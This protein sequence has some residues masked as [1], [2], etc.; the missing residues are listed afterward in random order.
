MPNPCKSVHQGR[1]MRQVAVA[2][3]RD[4]VVRDVSEV[5]IVATYYSIS[6][7][8]NYF[9][10]CNSLCPR[11]PLKSNKSVMVFES[12]LCIRSR[13]FP[14]PIA[15]HRHCRKVYQVTARGPTPTSYLG[16]TSAKLRKSGC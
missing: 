8:T 6:R 3:E 14:G 11:H 12:A 4:H 2:S 10:Y 1:R 5:S 9:V 16:S 7:Y 13:R 15:D